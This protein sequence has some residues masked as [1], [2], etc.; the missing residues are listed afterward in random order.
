[1]AGKRLVTRGP[2][3]YMGRSMGEDDLT[4][5]IAKKIAQLPDHI[6][7]GLRAYRAALAKRQDWHRA[8]TAAIEAAEAAKVPSENGH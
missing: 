4:G 8:V 1:V 7:A 5:A 3:V 2:S 6:Q